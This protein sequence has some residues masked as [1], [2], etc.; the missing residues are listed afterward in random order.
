MVGVNKIYNVGIIGFGGMA[1][2]HFK[3]SKEL[4]RINMKGVFDINP[5]RMEFAKANGMVTYESREALLNDPDIDI[6]LIA[7]PNDVHREIAIEA[8][9]R[10][11]KRA[12]RKAC[13]PL[14]AGNWKKL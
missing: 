9:A 12:V 6:V 11:Q 4:D 14:R 10:R 7:T 2:N 1:S 5:E 13:L 8:S 3:Q